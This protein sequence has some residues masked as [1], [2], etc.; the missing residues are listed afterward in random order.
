[1]ALLS[2]FFILYGCNFI[3]KLNFIN[4]NNYFIYNLYKMLSKS[5]L[6]ANLT[7]IFI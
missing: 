5:T 1:M 7:V 2:R 4:I 6:H 3:K